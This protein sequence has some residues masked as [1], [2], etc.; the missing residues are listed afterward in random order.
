MMQP[1][2]LS[3]PPPPHKPHPSPSVLRGLLAAQEAVL[4]VR[5]GPGPSVSPK[6]KG[7]DYMEN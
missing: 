6:L 4:E 2:F 3:R 5:T 1:V 7:R